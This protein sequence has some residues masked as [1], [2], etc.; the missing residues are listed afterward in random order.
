MFMLAVPKV[1]VKCMSFSG[2]LNLDLV[3]QSEGTNHICICLYIIFNSS[4][5]CS[6]EAESSIST[7]HKINATVQHDGKFGFRHDHK[8][9]HIHLTDDAKLRGCVYL[10]EG[11]K[12]LQ[13]DL[14][15]LD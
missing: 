4:G 14:D 11:R 5:T 15:R 13:Q 10:P 3:N 2:I 8:Q 9:R 6:A 12:A 1:N 7:S